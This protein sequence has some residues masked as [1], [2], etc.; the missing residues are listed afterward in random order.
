MNPSSKQIR[1]ME[2]FLKS[3]VGGMESAA[4]IILALA[5]GFKTA[6]GV[7]LNRVATELVE[8]SDEADGELQDELAREAAENS[9][10]YSRGVES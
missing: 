8:F 7:D 1:R 9:R 4:K 5:S 6:G 10:A 2:D 3:D